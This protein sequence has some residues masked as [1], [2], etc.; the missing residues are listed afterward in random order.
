MEQV[1]ISDA[2][3]QVLPTA[4]DMLDA[5]LGLRKASW[6]TGTRILTP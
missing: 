1:T 6:L 5:M 4:I 2:E 3:Y